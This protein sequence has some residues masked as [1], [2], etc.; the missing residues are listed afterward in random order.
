MIRASGTHGPPRVRVYFRKLRWWPG[1][2]DWAWSIPAPKGHP[3]PPPMRTLYG[4][5]TTAA[6]AAD[7]GRARLLE[8][9]GPPPTKD[10]P[11]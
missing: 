9:Y 7:A 4:R 6:A 2:Y 1:R 3:L 5:A 10:T 8:V 11:T